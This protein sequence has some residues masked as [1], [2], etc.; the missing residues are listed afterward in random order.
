MREL[1]SYK[2]LKIRLWSARYLLKLYKKESLKVLE[3]IAKGEP[4]SFNVEMTINNGKKI[5]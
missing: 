5:I 3:Y 1:I 2:N 4:N